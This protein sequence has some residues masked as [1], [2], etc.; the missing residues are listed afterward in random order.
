MATAVKA[1]RKGHREVAARFHFQR[2][3][4]RRQA[5]GAIREDNVEPREIPIDGGPLGVAGELT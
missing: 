1:A 2:R 4:V 5:A 3:T